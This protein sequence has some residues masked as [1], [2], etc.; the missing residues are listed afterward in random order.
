MV[1]LKG[2]RFSLNNIMFFIA[3]TSFSMVLLGYLYDAIVIEAPCFICIMQRVLLF[4]LSISA[5][6]HWHTATKITAAMG[7]LLDIR[8]VYVIAF[9]LSVSS[10]MPLDLLLSLPIQKMWQPLSHWFLTIGRECGIHVD[11]ITYILVGFLLCYYSAILYILFHRA[12]LLE[13]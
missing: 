11:P 6:L 3:I 8:H 2:H 5:Y 10:C 4:F 1:F 9:P 7:L 12:L 13:Q